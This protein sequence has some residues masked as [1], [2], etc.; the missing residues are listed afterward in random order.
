MLSL[1]PSL[2]RRTLERVTQ[3]FFERLNVP[4]F[5]IIERPLSQLY[6]ANSV[7][8]VVIDINRDV[9]DILAIIDTSIQR[10]T[11]QTLDIG[12]KDCEAHLANILRNNQPVIKALS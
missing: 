7:S 5:T 9:T 12:I 10:S 8:G 3:L 4:A 11:R 2:S 1:P 6:A